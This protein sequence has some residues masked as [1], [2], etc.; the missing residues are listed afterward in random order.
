MTFH[1]DHCPACLRA[2]KGVLDYPFVQVI[3]FERLPIPEAMDSF[4][5]AAARK[6]LELRRRE[7]DMRGW[8]EQGINMTPAIARACETP[9]VRDYLQYLEGLRGREVPS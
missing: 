5:E 3:S 6:Q 9:A 2:F 1:S 4:S 8:P 7:P